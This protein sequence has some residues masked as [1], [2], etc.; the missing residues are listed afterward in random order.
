MCEFLL[1]IFLG[2][3]CLVSSLPVV[4]PLTE[5]KKQQEIAGSGAHGANIWP[6]C[7][8]FFGCTLRPSFYGIFGFMDLPRLYLCCCR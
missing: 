7:F 2:R 8:L 4:W 3:K 5:A 1:G 6:A